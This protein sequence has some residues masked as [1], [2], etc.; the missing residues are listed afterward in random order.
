MRTSERAP[1]A[2]IGGG[3]A[4]LTAATI[5]RSNNVP[6]VL[7]EAGPKLAGLAT[8]FK[9]S[10]GFSYDFGAHFITN[11]LAAAIGVGAQCRDVRRYGE[12]VLL[13]GRTYG[14]PLGLMR[15]PRF[16]LSGVVAQAAS[17]KRSNEPESAAE[18]FRMKYGRAL[19][20]E[21]ALPLIEA[22]SGAPAAE[23][24]PTVGSSLPGS[25]GRTV[26][27][28]I[29]SYLTRRAVSCGYSREMPESP[30]VWHVY[31][32]GGVGV[33]C[34]RLARDIEDSIK[35][36][37]PV[38][39]VLV[40][41]NRAVAVRVKGREYEVS[42]VVSTAP[43]NILAKL[44]KGTDALKEVARFRYRPMV[45]VNMRFKGRGLLPD[46]VLWTPEDRF[47]FFRLTETSL[48]MPWLAPVGKT[49]ITVDIG[50]T[51]GD[52]IWSMPDEQLGEH[53]LEN[54]EPII[55]DARGRYMGCKVLRT[56][57]AYPVFLNEYEEER[58]RFELSSGVDGLYSV[59]RNG[60][61]AH[62][63]MEDVYWRTMKRTHQ[64]MAS[65]EKQKMA[66]APE[67]TPE[68]EQLVPVELF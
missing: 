17:I 1:V 45:F 56:P 37:S 48:S 10:D 8:T 41:D 55:R 2:I 53:C 35:L 4:G 54:L 20:D 3:L 25:I 47:P 29:A 24:A 22:W 26:T 59:G 21:V 61:F 65:L 14:Y 6:V 52:E 63:F 43:A 39:A 19:A 5:L 40:E 28:K 32:E 49:L 66:T 60:E 36:E 51:V 67:L 23:L 16:A 11:R 27:L 64:L 38:E 15:V 46:T 50:C 13:K 12:T 30:N 33:L 42:A 68:R 9:D 62:I 7:F 44:V 57:I 31:P 58:Q 18:W 34:Q